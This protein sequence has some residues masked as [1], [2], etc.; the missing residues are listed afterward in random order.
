MCDPIS[1]REGEGRCL[2]DSLR[3]CS[4][5]PF[6]CIFG[7]V[8]VL[9]FFLSLFLFLTTMYKNQ[10]IIFIVVV[11]IFLIDAFIDI[12]CTELKQ[13]MEI[14][15]HLLFTWEGGGEMLLFSFTWR[16]FKVAEAALDL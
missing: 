1:D 5:Y 3:E 15:Q 9:L 2:P 14:I 7:H 10:Y 11:L 6:F 8:S 13:W 16:V 12:G 4:H